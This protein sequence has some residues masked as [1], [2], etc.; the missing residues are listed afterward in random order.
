MPGKDIQGAAALAK[1]EKDL[2]ASPFAASLAETRLR[3]DPFPGRPPPL[4]GERLCLE[5]QGNICGD[6]SRVRLENDA[7]LE[8]IR[9]NWFEGDILI[10]GFRGEWPGPGSRTWPAGMANCRVRDCHHRQ[11]LPLPRSPPGTPGHRGR[12]RHRRRR[13]AGLPRPHLFSLGQAIHPGTE[14]A[15]RTVWLWD[16]MT[17]DD[18]SASLSMPREAQKEFQSSWIRCWPP[19]AAGSGMWAGR[20]RAACAACA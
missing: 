7:G 15:T 8:T 9:N 18:C 14:A 19:T 1:L 2:A 6:W 4:H 5:S 3:P 17:L 13:R 20:R 12:R 10:S 16:A 11:C